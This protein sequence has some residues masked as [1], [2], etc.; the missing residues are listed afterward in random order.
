VHPLYNVT[1]V[2]VI[3]VS[4]STR[5]I[6]LE[7][8]EK[9]YK[10]TGVDLE[11]IVVDNNSQ[12]KSVE[13]IRK[14]FPKV[15]MI[16]N[17]ENTGFGRANNQGM[18]VSKGDKILL[19]NSD[20]FVT[21]TTIST[22]EKAMEVIPDTQ[23][24]GCRLLNVDGSIQPSYGYFPTLARVVSLMFFIDNIPGIKRFFKSIHVRDLSRYQKAT[25]VDWVMGALVLLKRKV[26]ENTA[27][28]DE[29]Y[30]MYGEE[31][32][33]MYRIKDAGFSI[34]YIPQAEATHMGGASSG[35]KA[36]AIVGEI[37]GWKY[38][39]SKY[40]PGWQQPAL[41]VVVSLGCLLRTI[42]KPKLAKF[43]AQALT[44]VW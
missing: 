44:T 7:C 2:S 23:V 20:C 37:K 17:H 16:I 40:Y 8:L 18:S 14:R 42:T 33:W 22:L 3:I 13:A 39:F 36:S 9:L 31:V 38:W 11:V 21:P 27:G 25:E 15:T 12:D 6:T 19:L 29:K 1:M 26:W 30:F 24:V 28:F 5:E 32:E 43:Y 41:S 4:Y 35:N 34:R 10:S